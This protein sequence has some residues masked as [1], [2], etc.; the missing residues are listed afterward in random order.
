MGAA[1]L[2][3][4]QYTRVY[5]AALAAVLLTSHALC[6]GMMYVVAVVT[7]KWVLVEVDAHVHATHCQLGGGDKLVWRI[8]TCD[9]DTIKVSFLLSHS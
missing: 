1:G 2:R 6:W 3:T 7:G 5:T 9:R 4:V 8:I